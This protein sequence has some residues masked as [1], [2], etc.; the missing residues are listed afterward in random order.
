MKPSFLFT[1]PARKPRT[2]CCCQFVAFMISSMLAPSAR[3][4]KVRTR[5]CL[6]VL[7][8]AD[9][10]QTVGT[11]AFRDFVGIG[12]LAAASLTRR[13]CGFG[14]VFRARP[15]FFMAVMTMGSLDARTA[16]ALP[17]A[18]LTA[19]HRVCA[20][21]QAAHTH[22]SACFPQEV[23]SRFLGWVANFLGWVANLAE[24]QSQGRTPLG[25][26]TE[27]IPLRF[28]HSPGYTPSLPGD[29][30]C[31]YSKDCFGFAAAGDFLPNGRLFKSDKDLRAG[32]QEAPLLP[33]A[34]LI[35]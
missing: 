10:L 4:S 17:K 14:P 23:Q 13:S 26:Y 29:P 6:V 2:L 21:D 24:G 25:A 31:N 27:A 8:V 28:Q 30:T 19:G 20:E 34:R 9:L 5:S 32:L 11:G 22:T 3:V 15:G 35:I 33:S 18:P 7:S 1:V 12:A 16:S